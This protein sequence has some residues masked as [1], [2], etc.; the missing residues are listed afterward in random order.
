MPASITVRV[1]TLP[2]PQISDDEIA[3]WIE[4]RLNNA[5]NRFVQHVMTGSH[6]GRRYIKGVR[7]NIIHVASAPGE[8]PATDT[9]QLVNSVRYDMIDRHSG[10]LTSDVRHA[11]FLTEGTSHMAPRKMLGDVLREELEARPATDEL[12]RAARI[13]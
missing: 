2:T 5:R 3:R 9:G 7:G 6:G 13:T 4:G 1:P 11:R 12:A 10:E 8:Y